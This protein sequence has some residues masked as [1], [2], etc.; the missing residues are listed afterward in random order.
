MAPEDEILTEDDLDFI[1]ELP[2]D[3]EAIITEAPVAEDI[4]TD[5]T[6][7]PTN[8]EAFE[9]AEPEDPIFEEQTAVFESDNTNNNK[10]SQDMEEMA[11]AI[12]DTPEFDDTGFEITEEEP[13][14]EGD[15]IEENSFI[16][17]PIEEDLAENEDLPVFPAEE[18]SSDMSINFEQGDEVSHPK[19]GKGVVE[20]LIKYGNKTLC[21]IAFEEVGRRLLDP[22][23]SELQKLS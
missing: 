9:I 6:E 13:V 23:I 14:N 11:S 19:Y 10:I 18:S 15:T 1:D 20:K 2:Q 17:E 8:N 21:S 5:I 22:N 3:N 16:E 4:P 7:V 12:N